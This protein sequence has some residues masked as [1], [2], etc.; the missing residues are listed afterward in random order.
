MNK[1]IIVRFPPSPT[2]NLHIGNIRSFLFNYLFAKK[3]NGEIYLR[4][5]DTDKERSE[6]KYEEIILNTLK[7]LG[8]DFD[9]GPTWQSQRI[10]IYQ[11]ALEKLIENKNAYFA[12]ESQDGSGEKVIRFKN[13][14]KKIK[15]NDLIRG[16]IEIDTSDFGDFVIARS[17]ENPIYHLTVVVDDIESEISHIIRGEDHITSTPRQILLI[18]ALGGE[19]P[20][21]AHLPLLVGSDGKK[22]GKRHGAVSWPEFEKDGYL[23][24][25]LFNYLALLGWNPG[26]GE[27]QEFFSKEELMEKFSIENINKSPAKFS[28][29]K[30]DSINKYWM[31]RLSDEDYKK[32]VFNFLSEKML[33]NFNSPKGQKIISLVLKERVS[34]FSEILE[35]EKAGE[36]DYFFQKPNLENIKINFKDDG[37][38]KTKK[39]L[40]ELYE[41]LEEI[42]EENFNAKK[43]KEILWDW[44]GELGRG[45]VLHPFRT[46]LSGAEKS[47]DP[48]VL[49]EIL[50]KEETLSRLKNYL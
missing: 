5:E 29:E 32:N 27:E 17:L 3:N 49:A 1:K 30:L 44:S 13:P 12:E 16:E 38:E 8:L 28:Y 19:I 20:E 46:I 10:E 15:F 48:F 36:F 4:F 39:I 50:E 2:G 33:E 40:K 37:D 11:K 35:M 41:K 47:P 31:S 26:G 23:P 45:S 14:N 7:T 34:K 42:S 6:K 22:L 24:E 21:Y 43:I 25:S 9:F 18:E